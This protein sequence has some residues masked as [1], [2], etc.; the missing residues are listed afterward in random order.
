M[1]ETNHFMFVLKKEVHTGRLQTNS[2]GAIY[3]L[4]YQ[5]VVAAF[6]KTT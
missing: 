1:A 3:D 6:V 2:N 4:L 5:S